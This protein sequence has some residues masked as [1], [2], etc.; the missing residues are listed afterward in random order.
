MSTF[1]RL[2]EALSPKDGSSVSA[3]LIAVALELLAH[4]P[5]FILLLVTLV[6]AAGGCIGLV[7]LLAH[8]F[9]L[10]VLSASVAAIPA[11][12]RARRT[13]P[14]T[15]HAAA[16]AVDFAHGHFA[17]IMGSLKEHGAGTI[18]EIAERTGLDHVQVAR[19]LP[20]LARANPPVV[21]RTAERRKSPKGRACDVWAL[22]YQYVTYG[23]ATSQ[24]VR[25]R[26][27]PALK[28]SMQIASK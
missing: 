20:E 1:A 12:E 14:E 26:T 4:V 23:T 3:T 17:L 28:R 10:H 8:L 22:E 16:K 9:P 2:R 6:L 27:A 24:E 7:Y 19:R 15:S 18:Y 5:G 11:H 21:R 13:D 25:E